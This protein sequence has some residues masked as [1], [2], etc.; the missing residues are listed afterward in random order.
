[1]PKSSNQKLKLLY[2]LQ[3]LMNETDCEHQKSMAQIIAYLESRGISAERK[4]IYDD[5]EMLNLYG[6]EAGFSI[7]KTRGRSPGYYVDT[8][9]FELPE[10]RLLVDSVQSSKFITQSKTME[11]IR[12]L[13]GLA[14]IYDAQLLKSQVYVRKRVKSMNESVFLIIDAL[15]CAINTDSMIR[16]KYFEFT[17][18]KQKQ[19]KRNGKVYEVSPFTMIWD[20][21]NYYLLA[22]D[23]QDKQMKHF[24]V[25]KIDRKTIESAGRRREGKEVFASLDMSEYTKKVFGMFTGEIQRVRL[26]VKNYLVGSIFD[27]FGKDDVIVV[28]ESS[29]YFTVS[30]D[31]A[32]SDKF[33]AWVVGFGG[34]IEILSPEAAREGIRQLCEKNAAKYK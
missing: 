4:S 29:E 14:S 13:E 16:F 12:K 1:M 20:D 8:R 3:Y 21:E 26:K 7:E 28:P 31:A 32:I 22:W 19:Y 24:R 23:E 9:A 6:D 15:S 33:Y 17:V 5:I 34:D 11:L 2:L 18:G 27:R 30:I 10:L 25:D